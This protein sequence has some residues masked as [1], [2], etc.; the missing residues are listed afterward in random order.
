MLLEAVQSHPAEK[1]FRPVQRKLLRIPR[2]PFSYWVTEEVL[3]VLTGSRRLSEVAAVN[4]GM[5]TSNN[6]RFL[7]FSWEVDVNTNV[8]RRYAKAGNYC[9]WYGL[10]RYRVRWDQNGALIKAQPKSYVRNERRYFT[11]GLTYNLMARGAMGAR[12][13]RNS[14]FDPASISIFP[15]DPK[16]VSF[17]LGL[18]NTHTASYLLRFLAEGTKFNGGYVATFPLPS[19]ST[20]DIG[21]IAD[22][23]VALKQR[24]E[25]WNMLEEGF[26]PLNRGADTH[27]DLRET[28]RERCCLLILEGLLES[29]VLHAY[30]LDGSVGAVFYDTGTPAG[31]FSRIGEID[32]NSV[33]AGHSETASGLLRESLKSVKHSRLSTSEVS[34]L[35]SRLKTLFESG[36]GVTEQEEPN[37]D[38]GND[39]Q[40]EG[41]SSVGARLPIPSESFLDELSQKLT[42]HPLSVFLLDHGR[43][44]ERRMALPAGRATSWGGSN[45][46]YGPATPWASLAQADRNRRSNPRVGR[47]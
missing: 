36:T 27:I 46:R 35:K 14:A 16:E 5:T 24:L 15:S 17:L 10:E 13:L 4:D 18:L 11:D 6:E 42:C 33:F 21:T 30:G 8:W 37:T 34:E 12:I 20:V 26:G 32:D 45:H 44:G 38:D 29:L 31:L 2:A 19:G 39:D 47:L 3:R 43:N 7:R 41:S 25:N 28:M 40:L 1:T 23:C 9:K 22:E